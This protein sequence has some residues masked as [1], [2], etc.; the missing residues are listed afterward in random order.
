M[1]PRMQRFLRYRVPVRV[2]R[3]IKFTYCSVWDAY[4]AVTGNRP[5]GYPPHRRNFVGGTD[6]AEVGTE[7]TGHLRTLA[8]LKPDEHILDI[9]CGI[10]R[11]AIPLSGYLYSAGGY[12]G[13]DIRADGIAWCRD[14]IGSAFPNFRFAHADIRNTFYNPTGI[15][16]AHEFV[17]PYGDGTFDCVLAASVFT[18]MLGVDTLHYLDEISRVLKPGGR[19][20]LTFF[21]LNA[22]VHARIASDVTTAVFPYADADSPHMFF[23]HKNLPEAEIAYD[24]PWILDALKT[25]GLDDGLHVHRG[26][27]SGVQGLSYQDML[28]CRKAR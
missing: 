23:S 10:G 17:F 26:R 12:D 20:L 1:F 15:G 28:V 13:F 8:G 19:C 18:H 6:F 27:W 21:L 14:N 7:F 4:D 22:N 11:M 2:Q 24:E 5:K 9:G 3:A 16:A 25:R